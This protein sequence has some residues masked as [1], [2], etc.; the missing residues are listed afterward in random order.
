MSELRTLLQD[1]TPGDAQASGPL[2]LYPL[3]RPSGGGAMPKFVLAS[4][5]FAAGTLEVTE[6][7][8]AGV[9]AELLAITSGEFPILLIDGEEL[10]GA[11][12][13]RIVNTD[14]L[15][16]PKGR[17]TIPVSCVEQ[18]R[19]THVSTRFASGGYSPSAMRA[20]KSRAV[21][22]SLRERGQASSDQGEVWEDVE[23]LHEAMGTSSATSAMS[24]AIAQRRNDLDDLARNLH[25]PA[26]A[27]G[28]VVVINGQFAV[29]DL[30]DQPS[31]LAKLWDRLVVG[32]AMDALTRGD[33][34]AGH[35]GAFNVSE[36]LSLAGS[37]ACEVRPAVDLGEEWRFEAEQ[38][39][40]SALVADGVA[41]HLSV[42]PNTSARSRKGRAGGRIRGPRWRS[43]RDQ[44]CD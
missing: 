3:R 31:T 36:H 25:C 41:V 26:D 27:V 5:A 23:M 10:I 1:L 43:G 32:Y 18:G 4:E 30:F 19:W 6:V 35:A 2:A 21:S 34:D 33:E 11:K 12:Q 17:K 14:V 20:R 15:L 38:L 44:A 40:G 16:R 39:S 7:S 24:D 42:F 13:N 22:R 8:Q 9:V 28:V 29:L 37:I